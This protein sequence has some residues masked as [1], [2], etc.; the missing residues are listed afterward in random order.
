[1]SRVAI[2]SPASL[3]GFDWHT[4]WTA[5]CGGSETSHCEMAEGLKSAGFSIDSFTPVT[6]E[7]I[8]PGG[9][10]YRPIADFDPK[11]YVVVI[12][13]RNPALLDYPKVPGQ[14]TWFVAQDVSYPDWTDERLE[15]IDRY[16]CL[17]ESHSRYTQSTTA[18]L[19]GKTYISANGVRSAFVENF[20]KMKGA[21][22]PVTGE[23]VGKVP[24]RKNR[25]LYAS[26]PDR[27]LKLLLENWFRI[28][29]KV[30][31]AEL[32]VAY[33]FDNCLRIIE[34]QGGNDW[35]VGFVSEMQ[36]LMEQPGVTFTG[37]LNQLDLYK[38]WFEASVFLY[39]NDFAETFCC[40]MVD[41]MATGCWPVANRLWANAEHN[42]RMPGC[43]DFFSGV[44][45]KSALIKSYML[46]KCCERLTDGV[47]E[48]N[49]KTMAEKSR[50]VYDWAT[51][52]K[53]WEIWLE[54][55]LRK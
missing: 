7:S 38:E 30:P 6:E 37:R 1:V 20:E 47:L 23:W 45:Q 29:E 27:G 24:R 41:S 40:N 11:N 44:P 51:V 8:S 52:V 26:S 12:D 43:G 9:V 2:I 4:P 21:T 32:H 36:R 17:C 16:L 35:R 15:R 55:D 49:R 54:S 19:R 39:L 18:P 31:D 14:K 22:N 3:E 46:E 10:V 13:Y 25:L 33:G 42:D 34:M 28:R 48:I 5:G 50:R 53:Q